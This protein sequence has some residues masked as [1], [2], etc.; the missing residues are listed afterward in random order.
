MRKVAVLGSTGS[1]GT[2]A[3]NVIR[4]NPEKFK[5]VALAARSN[6]ELA[7]KQALEFKTK[8][9][10][11]Y[12]P[13]S[14]KKAR[15]ILAGSDIKIFEG[16]EG[17]LAAVQNDA[18]VVLVSL[19][20]TKGLLPTL[21]A[22]DD[23]KTIAI[24]TKEILVAA[25]RIVMSRVEKTGAR[26]VPVDSE[27]SAIFQLLAGRSKSEVAGLTLTASGGPFLNRP[28]E[29]FDSITVEEALKHPS[30]TMGV[31]ITI[32]SATLVNKGLEVIEAHRLFGFKPDEIEVVIHPQSI[33][34][35]LVR[36]V[37]GSAI[38]HLSNPDMRVPIAYAMMWPERLGGAIKPLDFSKLGSLKF[39]GVDHEKFPALALAYDALRLG[40]GACCA[41]SAADEVA[42]EAF[43]AH[44]IKFVDIYRVISEVMRNCRFG[45]LGTV[46]DVFECDKWA[47][48][49]ANEVISRLAG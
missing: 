19:S 34:H 3:L 44:R 43:V 48:K 11:L 39:Q 7:C 24:A 31:K 32:D 49:R 35:G 33:V 18:D 17:L 28:K 42:V 40:D 8:V 5:L 14:A 20:G 26:L 16:D 45:D 37:D 10:A 23:K 21:S 4:A 13:D 12:D 36:F 15:D 1:I 46:E 29:R 38:A 22:I 9:L 2:Q 6:V 41:L 30:W 27:H 47:L 25:G